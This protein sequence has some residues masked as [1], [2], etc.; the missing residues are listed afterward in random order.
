MRVTLHQVRDVKAGRATVTFESPLGWATA[1]WVGP[2]PV[3]GVT[4]QVAMVV[5]G[6][7]T[8]G[9]EAVATADPDA[10][11]EDRA[12]ICMVGRVLENDDDGFIT[13]A[14][15]DA[16][17]PVTL[18]NAPGRLPKRLLI[19]APLLQLFDVLEWR[20]PGAQA[21]TQA[22]M[23]NPISRQFGAHSDAD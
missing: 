15:G 16:V 22:L 8:W 3:E 20:T 21:A 4:R 10:I 6:A 18:A 11:F 9:Y 23:N 17:V 12:R 14:I 19:R 1:Q 13:L 7:L 2:R 5:P